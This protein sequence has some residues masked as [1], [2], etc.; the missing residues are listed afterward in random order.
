MMMILDQDS[1]TFL[2]EGGKLRKITVT[3]TRFDKNGVETITASMDVS[4]MKEV[5]KRFQ[6]ELNQTD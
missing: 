1:F 5:V 4:E 2:R 6:F 3:I